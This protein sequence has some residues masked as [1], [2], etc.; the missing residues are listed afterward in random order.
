[1]IIEQDLEARLADAVLH[2]VIFENTAFESASFGYA[3]LSDA[4]YG[5][6]AGSVANGAPLPV[7][8]SDGSAT[9]LDAPSFSFDTDAKDPYATTS[10]I[11]YWASYFVEPQKTPSDSLVYH[12]YGDHGMHITRMPGRSDGLFGFTYPGGSPSKQYKINARDQE[13]HEQFK[14]E[15][16][17]FPE[18]IGDYTK[19]DL[20]IVHEGAHNYARDHGHSS[21]RNLH[22]QNTRLFTGTMYPT[23]G[24]YRV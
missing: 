15:I 20:V 17:I 21:T 23:A 19:Q 7:I 11:D 14:P 10:T 12:R 24:A 6:S 4:S 1:M 3:G 9:R 13:M 22:E 16:V 8:P 5:S 18:E 2:N